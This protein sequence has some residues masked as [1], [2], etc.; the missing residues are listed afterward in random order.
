MIWRIVRKIN[1]DDHNEHD[2]NIDYI[3]SNEK[4]FICENINNIFIDNDFEK[5]KKES[6]LC[7]GEVQSGKTQNMIETIKKAVDKG[8]KLVIFIAG[9]T[10]MLLNQT[11]ERVNK[12]IK[13]PNIIIDDNLSIN[14][15]D[16]LN[17]DKC[18]VIMTL[19]SLISL[20][21]TFD[22]I[23]SID[24]TEIKTLII[25]DE[26][27]Y[28]SL[29]IKKDESKI[30]E[31]ISKIYDRIYEGKLL[32]FT[33]TPFGNLLSKNSKKTKSNRVV[34]LKNSDEY[35]GCKKFNQEK[36]N[37][38]IRNF[39]KN[40]DD[41]YC[42]YI[43]EAFETWM[44]ATSIA[45][46]KDKNFKSEFILNI[47]IDTNNH[48]YIKN[49]LTYL[50]DIKKENDREWLIDSLEGIMEKN[51]FSH[52]KNK[53]NEIADNWFYILKKLDKNKTI[54]V[55]NSSASSKGDN[56]KSG[57]NQFCIV[58]GGNMISRGYTFE[59]LICELFLN[60]PENEIAIDTL[61]QRCRWFG[62]RKKNME[63]IRIYI[64]ENIKNALIEAEHYLNVF[65]K[66]KIFYNPNLLAD[67]IKKI[68]SI[69]KENGKNVVS[70]NEIKRR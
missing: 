24:L 57:E 53:I 44:I 17:K 59:N 9:I 4:N 15:Q 5:E 62:Y 65:I 14:L 34:V 43:E 67:N 26:C 11:V 64:N 23:N 22:Y 69:N 18:V 21:K 20:K 51:N 6:V 41:Y 8:Y 49:E 52:Y 36:N 42:N 60:I 16:Y 55:L 48:Y 37:Y 2:G 39:N 40:N 68:D 32:N 3:K 31:L 25:D 45:L 66:G 19:K 35:C 30:H 50:L 61:L 54:F 13:N 46:L 63:Y 7:V 27:D 12:S 10:R 47:D 33:G 38:I 70:T 56:F 58:V 29:N 1:N 28:S